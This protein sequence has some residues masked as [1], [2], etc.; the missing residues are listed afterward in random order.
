MYRLPIIVIA[1]GTEGATVRIDAYSTTDNSSLTYR[2]LNGSVPPLYDEYISVVGDQLVIESVPEGLLPATFVIDVCRMWIKY[3][4]EMAG[5]CLLILCACSDL[6]HRHLV[7]L[8]FFFF[9]PCIMPNQF[10][11]GWQKLGSHFMSECCV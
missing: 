2:I 6:P 9:V 10:N 8:L 3:R 4:V 5:A 1:N 7:V 11:S